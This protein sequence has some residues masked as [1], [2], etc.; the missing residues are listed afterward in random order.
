MSPLKPYPG[1][2]ESGVDWL[3]A[4]PSGWKLKRVGDCTT[5]INGFPFDA[6]LFGSE[7]YPLI[8]IR[9]LDASETA[10]R[11]GGSDVPAA[12]VTA[13]DLL[14]GMDGDFNVGRWRGAEPAL[15]NQRMMALRGDADLL[16]LLEHALPNP[17]RRINDLTY[18]TT[19]KHLAASQVEAIRVALPATAQELKALVAYLERETAEVDDFI[20]QQEE[21]IELLSERRAA[22]LLSSTIWVEGAVRSTLGRFLRKEVRPT[23][24]A[25]VVTAFRD[26]Q[27]TARSNRREEGFTMSEADGGYQ[28][29]KAGDLVFHGLDGFAG[30][31]GVSDSTGRCSPVYH[32]CSTSP[33]ADVEFVALYLRALG[34]A[35]LLEAYAWS[36]RQRSVDYRNWAI[37]SKLPVSLPPIDAQREQVLAMNTAFVEIDGAIADARE[38]IALS[39]ERRAALVLAAVTG[40]I[41]VRAAA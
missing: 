8:R 34:A 27:V 31:V 18:A 12:R 35:G 29:V 15:L 6:K 19:V 41:D 20:A 25:E 7:G 22:V 38:A 17:L 33:A 23:L 40:K 2:K 30:A 21:L 16:R 13:A 10:V 32:V 26:G 9:D 11:F 28:G 3:G 4:I 37:F 39:R 36:V 24:G 14:I 5:V 1:Y